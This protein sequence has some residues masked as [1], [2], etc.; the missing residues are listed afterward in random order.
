[1]RPAESRIETGKR[2]TPLETVEKAKI[3]KGDAGWPNELESW[4]ADNWEE[5]WHWREF[6]WA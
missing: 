3:Q 1:M 6:R 2:K 5:C 4:E